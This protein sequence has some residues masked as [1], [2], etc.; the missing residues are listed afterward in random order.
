MQAL[1]QDDIVGDAVASDREA[2][3]VARPGETADG[4][5]VIEVSEFPGRRTIEWLHPKI[6]S[7]PFVIECDPLAVWRPPGNWTAWPSCEASQICA[8]G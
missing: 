8:S 1:E 2:F 4:A 7:A 6:A 3:A 5:V